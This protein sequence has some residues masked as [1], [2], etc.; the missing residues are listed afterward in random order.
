MGWDPGETVPAEVREPWSRLLGVGCPSV[1]R[2]L[3]EMA[4]MG[5]F[6]SG[7]EA[8]QLL[9]AALPCQVCWVQCCSPAEPACP[10]SSGQQ[11]VIGHGLQSLLPWPAAS[12]HRDVFKQ[13]IDTSF[14]EGFAIPSPGILPQLVSTNTIPCWGQEGLPGSCARSEHAAACT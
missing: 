9:P 6:C 3:S 4:Q 8:P 11:S 10:L 13:T 5:L 1:V 2:H 7:A 14:T 12:L